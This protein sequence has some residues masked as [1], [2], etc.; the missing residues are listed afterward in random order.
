MF[1]ILRHSFESRLSI[2]VKIIVLIPPAVAG[3]APPTQPSSADTSEPAS[4][5]SRTPPSEP[6]SPESNEMKK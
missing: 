4:D 1:G 6:G 5:S 3:W 2:Q